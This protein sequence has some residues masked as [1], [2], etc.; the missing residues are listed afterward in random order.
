M[1]GTSVGNE[2]IVTTVPDAGVGNIYFT[3]SRGSYEIF[4]EVGEIAP[5]M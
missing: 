4:G 2:L 3:K 5:F 1:L